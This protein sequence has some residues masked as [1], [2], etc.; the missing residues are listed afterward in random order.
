M[1]HLYVVLDMSDAMKDQD[2]RPNRL[3]CSIEVSRISLS[4]EWTIRY[5]FLS[6]WKNLSFSISTRIQSLKSV[7]SLHERNVSKKSVNSLAILVHMLLYSNNWNIKNVKVKHRFKMHSKLAYKH[8]SIIFKTK[9]KF[10]FYLRQLDIC[11]N[12][13]VEKCFLSSDV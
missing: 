13:P 4:S 3:F 2:L 12:I 1:R 7:F 9:T 10:N 5:W 11:R 8:W 6:C